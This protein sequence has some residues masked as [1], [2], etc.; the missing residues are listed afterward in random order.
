MGREPGRSRS[1]PKGKPTPKRKEQE[2]ARKQARAAS[3]DT[4]ARFAIALTDVRLEQDRQESRKR[5]RTIVNTDGRTTDIPVPSFN[6]D[7]ERDTRL[8]SRKGAA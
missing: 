4:L 5:L 3:P 7:D 8:A 6:R 2:L 1:A